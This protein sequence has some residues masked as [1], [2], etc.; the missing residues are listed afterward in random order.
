MLKPETDR[1]KWHF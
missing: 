1:G